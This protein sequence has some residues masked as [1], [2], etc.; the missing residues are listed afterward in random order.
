MA[1]TLMGLG[2]FRFEI[3]GINYSQLSRRFHYRWEPQMRIGARPMQQFLGP[4]EEELRLHGVLFPHKY[5]GYGQLNKMRDEAQ[6]GTPYNLADA[7][8]NF[9]G[10]WC[11]R[12]I[13]DEQEFFYPNGA[14]RRV[15]F[16]LELVAYGDFLAR[17]SSRAPATLLG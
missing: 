13:T 9:Y 4:G 8:G 16:D 11:I 17:R 3:P 2:S 15:E 5:G 1:L 12:L 10:K 7:R 6:S 14:P